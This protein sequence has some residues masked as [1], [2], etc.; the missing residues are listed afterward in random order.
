MS[1]LWNRGAVASR[2]KNLSREQLADTHATGGSATTLAVAS[3]LNRVVNVTGGWPK[4]ISMKAPHR[5]HKLPAFGNERSSERDEFLFVRIIEA[6]VQRPGR[7]DDLCKTCLALPN[8]VRLRQVAI[9]RRQVAALLL[10]QGEHAG[11]ATVPDR[12]L[13]RGPVRLLVSL[14]PETG[15]HVLE[16]VIERRLRPMLDFLVVRELLIARRGRLLV[17]LCRRLL[18]ALC[19]GGSGEDGCGKRR[20]ERAFHDNPRRQSV[21]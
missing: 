8:T 10:L 16:L 5:L 20:K 11:F 19:E 18:I 7:V 2:W 9:H 21:V 14:Q 4:P 17:A 15:L 6:C 1:A 13:K 12:G 3:E